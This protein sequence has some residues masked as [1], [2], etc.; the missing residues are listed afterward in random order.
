MEDVSYSV[1]LQVP[2]LVGLSV[3][4]V[5]VDGGYLPFLVIDGLVQGFQLLLD[6]LVPLL[7]GGELTATALLGIQVRPFLC[8]LGQPVKI[9]R[10]DLVCP[11]CLYVPNTDQSGW[12]LK[13][14]YWKHNGSSNI[15][16]AHHK[17]STAGINMEAE[18]SCP[19]FLKVLSFLTN[20]T[21][22]NSLK[23]P[24]DALAQRTA[25][26]HRPGD[27]S[28]L[29]L[30]HRVELGLR[31]LQLLLFLLY[32]LQQLLTLLQQSFLIK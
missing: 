28:L 26:S 12:M 25:A 1:L 30:F 11:L 32:L 29:P 2:L 5:L 15:K 16:Q 17:Q 21:N 6:P 18:R 27:A 3:L 10:R 23:T 31:L 24:S 19:H 8:G 9:K 22:M 14:R 7:L 13:Q 20:S 4:Q